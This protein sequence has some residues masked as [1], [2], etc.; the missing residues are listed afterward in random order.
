MS[1][2]FKWLVS[3]WYGAQLGGGLTSERTVRSRQTVALTSVCKEEPGRAL[4]VN[5]QVYMHVRVC[6]V[7]L[8][9]CVGDCTQC[10]VLS[11]QA[12]YH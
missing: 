9:F 12:L 7:S 8:W 2:S 5:R 1:F 4:R 6:F 10:F 3:I 11:R